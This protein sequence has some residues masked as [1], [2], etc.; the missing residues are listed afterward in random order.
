[1]ESLGYQAEAGSV[2]TVSGALL[3]PKRSVFLLLVLVVVLTTLLGVFLLNRDH[4]WGDDF[5]AYIMQSQSIVGG[6]M[7]EYVASNGFTM[8]HTSRVI[9]PV[10]YP[11]GFPLLLA[12]VYA[13]FGLKVLA[14][15]TV[16][17]FFHTLFVMAFFLLAR[18]RLRAREALVLTAV[19]GFNTALLLAQNEILADIPF[20]FF[21]TLGL[22]L[23]QRFVIEDERDHIGAGPAVAIGCAIFLATFMRGNGFLLL[24]PLM[25][26]QGAQFFRR[27]R[28]HRGFERADLLG[29]LPYAT[30]VLL[31]LAQAR[32]FP[33][34]PFPLHEELGALSM[35]SVWRNLQFYFWLPANMF[36]DFLHGGPPIYLV[37][38]LGC[39]IQLSRWR[40]RDLPFLAYGLGTL[41]FYVLWPPLQ[42]LRYIFPLLPIFILFS[43]EGMKVIVGLLKPKHRERGLAF[44]FDLWV[45][46]AL[47][48]LAAGIQLAWTNVAANRYV[49]GRSYG[50]FSPGSSAMFEYV[51]EKTPADSVIIFFKPR[52]M[53][54]RAER[55]T[56]S[57]FNCQDLTD[58]DYVAIVKSAGASDQILPQDVGHCNPAVHLTPVYEKD[59]FVVYQIDPAL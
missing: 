11:W 55:N 27:S 18:A 24:L 50:A 29:L 16:S 41:A 33:S 6:T 25:T 19:L 30:V 44:V 47:F 46:L 40:P 7:Q 58:G 26:A 21:S 17:T 4:S 53:R 1:M 42:G 10:T 35:T 43:F 52:A 23:I 59:D 31:N 51:R 8:A 15:K 49:Y 36:A 34:L 45:A 14:L 3:N 32:V 9:G 28:V 54:L 13:V 39:M 20:L 37:L 5:A 56:F 57:T 38:L 48:S 22:W 12:P 2:N